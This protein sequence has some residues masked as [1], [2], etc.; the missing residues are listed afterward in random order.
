[1]LAA[2]ILER[3]AFPESLMIGIEEDGTNMA[4]GTGAFELL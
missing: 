2:Y 1:M 3:D 4:A